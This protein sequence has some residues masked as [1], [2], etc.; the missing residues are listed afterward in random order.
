[1]KPK[2]IIVMRREYPNGVKLRRGKEIAQGAHASQIATQM[3]AAMDTPAYRAWVAGPIAKVCVYVDTEQELL[4]LA[5]K[6]HE[7]GL[8]YGLITDSGRTEFHGVPTRTALGIG[9]ADAEELD[10]I[11]GHLPLY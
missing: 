2:Q 8:P 6:A 3:A 10:P 1:M 11:T 9:P 5:Q 7:A 4:E